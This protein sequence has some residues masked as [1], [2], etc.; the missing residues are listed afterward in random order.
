MKNV[1]NSATSNVLKNLFSSEESAVDRARRVRALSPVS[2]YS[3][4]VLWYDAVSKDAYI[5]GEG[6]VDQ[7]RVTTFRDTNPQ[8]AAV[9]KNDANQ[10][11]LADKPYYIKNAFNGLPAIRGAIG[12]IIHMSLLY[13]DKLPSFTN[14]RS[15]FIAVSGIKNVSGINKSVFYQGFGVSGAGTALSIAVSTTNLSAD[16]RNSRWGNSSLANPSSMVITL[17]LPD[18]ANTD[19]ITIRRNGF[20]FGAALDAG[21]I[22]AV[23]TSDNETRIRMGHDYD[24]H[25][26][27]MYSRELSSAEIEGVENYL[28]E[29][30][31][32]AA[33]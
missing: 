31:H 5:S 6:I 3:D 29:K 24:I 9:D 11:V 1:L 2:T 22:V 13:P 28:A 16:L 25:E 26:I 30:W 27:I 12:S 19:D 17:T 4:L 7:S 8:V 15:I 14:Q 33:I 18:G 32:I 20:D 23:N 10:T 21:S